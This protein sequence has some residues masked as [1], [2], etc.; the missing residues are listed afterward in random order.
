MSTYSDIDLTF[1]PHPVTGDIVVRKDAS[2]VMQSIR[3][4]IM[5]RVGETAFEEYFGTTVNSTLFELMDP[6]AEQSI[7]EKIVRAI[8]TYE[9]RADLDSVVVKLLP[10]QNAV[11]V[12]IR[13]Y[14]LNQEQP[15]TFVLTLGRLR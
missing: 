8:N 10:T 12:S 4:I 13:F 11:D 2:A 14:I 5:T 15:F 1:L 3:N 9:P 6:T 7:R